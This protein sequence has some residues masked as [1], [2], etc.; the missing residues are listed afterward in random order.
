[1]VMI[2]GP[3]VTVADRRRR[4]YDMLDSAYPDRAYALR[5][6]EQAQEMYRAD[7]D[8]KEACLLLRSA[9][10]CSRVADYASV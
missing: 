5:W 8:M 4:A 2:G 1:M 6:C 10:G 9:L 3:G 7:G